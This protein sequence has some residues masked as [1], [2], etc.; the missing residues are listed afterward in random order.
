M[1]IALITDAAPME[2]VAVDRAIL[3]SAHDV[4]VAKFTRTISHVPTTVR[5]VRFCN[6]LFAWFAGPHCLLAVALAK[7]FGK[8]I[9]VAASDYDLADEPWFQYG[10]MR[11]GPRAW[12]NNFIFRQADLIVVPSEFSRVMALKNTILNTTPE[13]IRVVPHGFVDLWPSA[14]PKRKQIGTVGTVNRENWIRKGHREFVQAAP[15]VAPN[16][17][18]L[19]GKFGEP[20]HVEG[21]RAQ[22]ASNLRMTGFLTPEALRDLLAETQVYVQ[23]SYMEGFGCSLAEAMLARCVPVVTGNA[24]LP[25]V[26]DDC[27]YYVRYGDIKETAEV[28]AQALG[29]DATAKRARERVLDCFSYERR[30]RELTALIEEVIR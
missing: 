5:A 18:Y 3:G 9:I 24:A 6:M 25:E 28:I 13:K 29:D 27:G 20:A 7:A 14:A 11:G 15:A 30:R 16:P 23:V 2:Y 8:P 22:A 17:A 26:V 10:S 21:V 19:A 12:I 4:H 1:R